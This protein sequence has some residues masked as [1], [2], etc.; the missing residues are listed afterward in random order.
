MGQY[1]EGTAA[2]RAQHRFKLFQPTTMVVGAS[3]GSSL[4]R[5]HLLDLSAT[6]A[7][8]HHAAP[9]TVGAT[10]RLECAG[11]MRMAHVV[12]ISGSRFGVAFALPLNE[13]QLDH[14]L[15]QQRDMIAAHT[16][17]VGAVA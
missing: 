2:A 9:P 1:D 6:G 8:V 16:Q 11:R 4:L 10:V 12:W 3:V 15:T 13:H 17:R 7:L 14:A 5:V